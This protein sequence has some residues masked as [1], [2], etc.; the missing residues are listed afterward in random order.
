MIYNVMDFVNNTFSAF[1][2]SIRKTSSD[3]IF[4]DLITDDVRYKA[5]WDWIYKL[6]EMSRIEDF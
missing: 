2:C 3:S 5:D 4:S 6:N 1:I